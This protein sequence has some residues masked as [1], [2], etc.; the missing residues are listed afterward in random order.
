M[1]YEQIAKLQGKDVADALL[2]RNPR[3]AIQGE[4]LPF[5]PELDEAVGLAPGARTPRSKKR[6]WF[7]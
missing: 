7:F 5:V 2:V 3:A 1:A 6:F 4:A